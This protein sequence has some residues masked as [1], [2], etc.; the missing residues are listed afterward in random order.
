MT[1][2]FRVHKM[3]GLAAIAGAGTVKLDN[4]APQPGLPTTAF[5]Y[6]LGTQFRV[7][8]VGSFDHGMQLGVEAVYLHASAGNADVSGFASGFAL[9]PFVGYKIISSGGFTFDGQLGVEFVAAKAQARD[10]GGTQATSS[11]RSTI[12]LLNLNIGWSF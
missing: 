11:D 7:Y 8:P 1:G 6:E 2:E 3:M 10:S 5:V 9:G 4:V 12:P